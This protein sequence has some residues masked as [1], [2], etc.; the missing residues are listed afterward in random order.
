[1]DPCYPTNYSL[2]I[3]HPLPNKGRGGKHGGAEEIGTQPE[4]DN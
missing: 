1:V 3:I 2:S 4:L